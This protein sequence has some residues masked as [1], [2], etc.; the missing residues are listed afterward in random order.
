MRLGD[1]PVPDGLQRR[2]SLEALFDDDAID[3]LLRGVSLPGGLTERVLEARDRPGRRSR[4]VDL[5]RHRPD[6]VPP[7]RPRPRP[8]AG[9]FGD[10]GRVVAIGAGLIAMV[11]VVL[12]VGGPVSSI[13]RREPIEI[14]HAPPDPDFVPIGSGRLEWGREPGPG[15]VAANPPVETPE[16]AGSLR[17]PTVADPVTPDFVF[18]PE[19]APD[20]FWPP[21]DAGEATPEIVGFP[22]VPVR[23]RPAADP[24]QVVA[25]L[26]AGSRRTVP[27][28]PAYDLAFELKFGEPPF[29][30]PAAGLSRDVP[31]LT[32]RTSSFDAIRWSPARRIRRPDAARLRVEDVLAAAP[33][34]FDRRA[35]GDDRPRLDMYGVRSLRP[36]T[37]ALVE[38]AVTAPRLSRSRDPMAAVLVLDRSV[39]PSEWAA[40]CHGLRMLAAAMR[41]GD[42]LT[43]IV[44]GQR[45]RV[46]G[47]RL[48]PAAVAAAVADLERER[49]EPAAVGLDATVRNARQQ[50]A[51]GPMVLVT[52]ADDGVGPRTDTGAATGIVVRAVPADGGSGVDAPAV[53][54]SGDDVGRAVIERVYGMSAR[55]ATGCRLS[56]AFDPRVVQAYRLVGHRQSAVE[57]LAGGQPGPI[58][59]LAGQTVRVVYEVVPQPKP[60][61]T[62][63][64]A[65]AT[66]T[67]SAAPGEATRS[68]SATLVREAVETATGGD[69]SPPGPQT[70]LPSP[71]GCELLLAVGLGELASGSAHLGAR[72]GGPAVADLVQGWRRRGDVSAWGDTLIDMLER[73]GFVKP[74]RQGSD[75]SR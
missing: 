49:P 18:A 75:S 12:L 32:V 42:R 13:V 21:A 60:P 71:R 16:P 35:D 10:R 25:Q 52:G 53:S 47:E 27:R 40:T 70:W 34:R 24:M 8:A 43:I 58:D 69:T 39:A 54:A 5:D 56:V 15:V 57:S 46:V 68:V 41:G 3:R 1:V 55:V 11:A 30:Y 64:L 19:G 63:P 23:G 62:G 14:V 28:S 29:V 50:H 38:I 7:P 6:V 51:S 61:A 31:P 45:M 67:W 22:V 44:V 9:W 66:F 74:A 72:V 17:E 20:E 2:L 59:M 36:V 73:L 26:P 4:S 37:A 33:Q 48:E 65:E